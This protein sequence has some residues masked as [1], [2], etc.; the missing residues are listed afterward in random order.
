MT[1]TK[2]ELVFFASPNELRL[3]LEAH[4]AEAT[5]LWVGFFKKGSGRPSITWSEAVDQALCFGWIDSVGKGIDETRY[6]IRFTPRRA[7]ST[8]S[9]VNIKRV[10]E[11]TERGLMHPAGLAAFAARSEQRSAIYAHE[12]RDEVVLPE[13]D[14]GELRAN[15][16]AW[17]FFQRQPASY[18]RAAIWWVVS[19]KQKATQR[20]RLATLIADSA[21]GRTVAP[22]TRPSKKGSAEKSASDATPR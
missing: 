15:A 2:P 21:N 19:A 8:W 14:A 10:P 4:H 5:E 12:Q 3:W 20:R 9:R 1:V 6:T 7:R 22:L 11:L 17:D 18:Q 16:A 13:E